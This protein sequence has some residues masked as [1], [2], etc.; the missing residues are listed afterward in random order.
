M[1]HNLKKKAL[2]TGKDVACFSNAGILNY[3][4]Q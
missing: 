1:K 2:V 4:I 3:K